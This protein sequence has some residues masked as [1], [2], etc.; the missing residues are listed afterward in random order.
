MRNLLA[1]SISLTMAIS[2]T[3]AASGGELTPEAKEIAKLESV[4]RLSSA[5]LTTLGTTPPAPLAKYARF[6]AGITVGGH[7]RISGALLLSKP[8]GVRVVAEKN[9]PKIMDGGCGIIHLLYDP[10]TAH[11][12][13]IKCNGLA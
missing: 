9:L 5:E 1:L 4:L 3:V 10:E 13:W 8:S 7:R 12:I 11:V 2:A 6:Y